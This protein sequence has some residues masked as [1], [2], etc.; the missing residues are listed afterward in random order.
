MTPAPAI[1]TDTLAPSR[2]HNHQ[3][4]Q[5][6]EP[7]PTRDSIVMCQLLMELGKEFHMRGWSLGTSSNYSVVVNENPFELLITASGRDKS[8]LTEDEFVL[9]GDDG[10]PICSGQPKSSAE[11]LLHVELARRPGIGSVLH[12]H[13]VWGTILSDHYAQDGFLGITGYEMLKGL[14][15]ITTHEHTE[16]VRI[17][18]NT[19]NIPDLAAR[20]SDDLDDNVPGLTH[21]LLL[22]NHGLYT[23]GKDLDEARRHVEVFEFLFEVMGRKLL[24]N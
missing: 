8:C 6:P 13:S 5:T 18:P 20:L 10:D 11:T 19:Q 17:Y 16:L 21:G 3:L 2:N 23:W 9:V 22:Q 7:K 1:I 24:K 12:T 4:V 15:G 14:V